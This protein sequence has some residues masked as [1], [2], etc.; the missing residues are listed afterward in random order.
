MKNKPVVYY[1]PKSES[2]NIFYIL[3]KVR[4]EL[5]KQ[6][7]IQ[8]FNDCWERVQKCSNYKKALKI[9]NEYVELKEI[10]YV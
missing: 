6:R 4:V 5:R 9:I 1:D 2:G 7:R 10:S 3:A 8:D